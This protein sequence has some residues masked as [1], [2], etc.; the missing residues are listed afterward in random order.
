VPR[1][2][3]PV[4]RKQDRLA[5]QD[6]AGS[7]ASGDCYSGEKQQ[8]PFSSSLLRL[9]H[10]RYIYNFIHRKVAKHKKIQLTM[11][12]NNGAKDTNIN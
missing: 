7:L 10:I 12:N 2:L 6:Q 1:S 5:I 3:R 9:K 8:Q 11:K 4:D